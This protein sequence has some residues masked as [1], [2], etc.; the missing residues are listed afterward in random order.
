[1]YHPL[2]FVNFIVLVAVAK[3][4]RVPKTRATRKANDSLIF[5]QVTDGCLH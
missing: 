4:N 5:A 2:V 3:Q 1:M